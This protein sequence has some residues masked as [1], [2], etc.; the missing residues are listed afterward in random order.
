MSYFEI[1]KALKR[2][3]KIS[4]E[5]ASGILKNIANCQG[6]SFAD[7]S[8]LHNNRV[9]VLQ[10][11]PVSFAEHEPKEPSIEPSEVVIIDDNPQ[12]EEPTY[13]D[14]DETFVEDKPDRRPKWSYPKSELERRLMGAVVGKKY[15][16]KDDKESLTKLRTIE[17][18]MTPLANGLDQK[19]PIEWVDH[20]AEW[21][22]KQNRE[23]YI[24]IKGFVT[25]LNNADWKMKFLDNE[26]IAV[27][28]EIKLS[29]STVLPTHEPISDE[30]RAKKVKQIQEIRKRG[31]PKEQR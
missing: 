5:N 11:P 26:G 7:M 10:T 22:L 3:F 23:G 12:F 14:V 27:N 1:R 4:D 20:V 25:A 8:D 16:Q 9:S 17:K 31:K 18:S 29:E 15:W 30:E 21:Y 13:V 24:P 2:R 19:Y 6:V 28:P